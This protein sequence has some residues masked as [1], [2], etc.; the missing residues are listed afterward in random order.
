MIEAVL[1]TIGDEI[2]IGQ[3]V[4]TNSTF[5][6]KALNSI[7]VKVAEIVS[8]ADS[9]EEII[10]TLNRLTTQ[11]KI[12]ILTGG[13]GPTKDDITKKSIATFFKCDQFITSN[14]QLQIIEKIFA[15]RGMKVTPINYQQALVPSICE[16]ITNN[17]GTAPAML[18]KSLNGGV[19]FSLPG[20]PYEMEALMEKV[21]EIIKA[22]FELPKI[23]HKTII[24]YGVAE[25]HL[26][27]QL[28]EWEDSLPQDVKLAY[29]PNPTIGIRL[30]LSLY[31]GEKDGKG[32]KLIEQYGKELKALLTPAVQYGEDNDTLASVI[33]ELLKRMGA[34]LSIAESCTG[35]KLAS[36]MTELSGVSS[37]FTGGVVTY[38]NSA[39]VSLLKVDPQ[40]IEEYGAVSQE[41]AEAMATGCNSIFKSDYS[42]A[43]TGV[44][45]PNGGT[46]E[47]PVGTA[48]ISIL[49]PTSIHSFSRIFTGDRERNILR[50]SSEAL[51]LLRKVIL[52]IE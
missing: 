25:S 23:Y 27:E 30:R 49:T 5:I 4:D 7:G 48:W 3:I 42:I 2:L 39:K 24:T 17:K 35:G 11:Y 18:F 52:N 51:N 13:L 1:C 22:R 20:V 46:K 31:N 34:T 8:I 37:I 6:S 44:A 9:S 38:S 29:L 21:L 26:A 12:V 16:V 43:I 36:T 50:T 47:K 40:I 14:E 32:A 33:T 10:Q 28:S 15:S 19:L 41:C 45:G